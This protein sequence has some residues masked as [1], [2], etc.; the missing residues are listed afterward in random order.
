MLLPVS[1]FGRKRRAKPLLPRLP[2]LHQPLRIVGEVV[3]DRGPLKPMTAQFHSHAHR[4]LAPRSVIRH[5]V[6]H[7]PT[8][9]EQFFGGQRVEKGRYDGDI[10][11]L[12]EQFSA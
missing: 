12:L 7:I 2:Q 8:I 5:E 4:S 3:L 11:T 1:V 9:V 10:V 6:L